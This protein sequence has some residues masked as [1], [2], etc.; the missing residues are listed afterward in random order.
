MRTFTNVSN[1]NALYGATIYYTTV[2]P[3]VMYRCRMKYYL[4]IIILSWPQMVERSGSYTYRSGLGSRSWNHC[5][6]QEKK[7]EKCPLLVLLTS[8]LKRVFFWWKCIWLLCALGNHRHSVSL[9]MALWQH[10]MSDGNFSNG[11]HCICPCI[12]SAR[13]GDASFLWSFRLM[14][15]ACCQEPGVS[16]P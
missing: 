8:N 4:G 11:V 1:Y 15:G 12:I 2:L 13:S 16:R 10:R 9:G 3:T 7:G 14:D 5:S 6:L